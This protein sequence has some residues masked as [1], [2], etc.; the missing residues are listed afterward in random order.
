MDV[1]GSAIEALYRERYVAFRNAVATITGDYDDAR[2]AVQEG[3]TRAFRSRRQLRRNEALEGWVWR[4]VLR[5]AYEQVAVNAVSPLD[6]VEVALVD[7][8]LDPLLADAMRELSPR[9]RLVVFL[10][11][12]GDLSYAQIA[13]L[14]EIA[15]G[16]VAATIA[17]A[18]DALG[19]RLTRGEVQS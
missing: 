11:F 4:I 6:E 16:T 5:A 18:R 7:P 9:R 3:F 13:D 1:L 8:Q 14:C 12:F 19:E 2:D 15:E 17:Q 10:R